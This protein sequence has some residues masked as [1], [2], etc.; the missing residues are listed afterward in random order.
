MPRL[1]SALSVRPTPRPTPVRNRLVRLTASGL[2]ALGTAVTLTTVTEGILTSPLG[3]H[4]QVA[5]A[6]SL[7]QA[8]QVYDKASPAVVTIQTDDAT[9]SGSII[10]ANGLV[11]TNAHVVGQNQVVTVVLKDGRQFK[12]DVIAKAADCLDLALVQLRQVGNLPTLALGGASTVR[13]A[14]PVFAIGS[15]YN[16]ADSFSAGVVSRIDQQHGEVQTTVP[17]NPGNSGGPLLNGKGEIIGVNT[18]IRAGG[19]NMSFSIALDPVQAF[20]RDYQTGAIAQ[21]PKTKAADKVQTITL[22]QETQVTGKL[23]SDDAVLCSDGT[24]YDRYSLKGE[25]GQ[26]VMIRLESKALKPV[27]ALLGPDGKQVI[28]DENTPNDDFADVVLQLPVSGTYTIIANSRQKGEQGTYQLRVMPLILARS[29]ALKVGDRLLKDGSLYQPFEFQGQ[30]N[31]PVTIRVSSQEFDPYVILL[32]AKGKQLAANDD[33]ATQT[34]NS[35]LSMRLPQT[36]TY[37]V[38]VNA[39]KRGQQG[40]FNLVVR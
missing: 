23:A 19:Q 34:T 39:A 21:L 16:Q 10:Q 9:G 8:E 13:P 6:E 25:A 22:Q 35:L 5:Q 29:G 1:T 17:L 20:L 31:Q 37:T 32:D 36:G 28:I 15:P 12:A 14:Q 18:K 26:S 24:L 27:V 3:P 38:L 40:A 4:P 33:G 30:A 11:L 2:L 7:T